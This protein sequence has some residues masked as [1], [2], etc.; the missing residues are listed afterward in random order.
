MRHRNDNEFRCVLDHH[1]VVGKAFQNEPFGSNRSG[2][3]E[4]RRKRNEPCFDAIDSGFEGSEEICAK[5][6]TL[7]FVLCGCFDGLVGG[8]PQYPYCPHHSRSD[9]V[10]HSFAKLLACQKLRLAC[11]DL[12][13]P[14]HDLLV[15]R[16]FDGIIPHAVK[17]AA[18]FMRE[19]GAL[20][21]GK[22]R[23]L[24]T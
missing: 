16:L 14:T 6:R 24:R 18:E 22:R 3:A 4:V 2:F 19:R 9:P 7:P 12:C 1:D 8:L 5:A 15:P 11:L 21:R 10:P 17:A 13:D 20:R 23:N